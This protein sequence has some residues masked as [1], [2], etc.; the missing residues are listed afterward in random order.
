MKPKYAGSKWWSISDIDGGIHWA[1][2]DVNITNEQIESEYPSFYRGPGQSFAHSVFI[3]R[4][5]TRVLV[6]QHFG[7]D[8]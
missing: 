2:F 7:W 3:R 6:T 8:V 4:S 5:K 1:V